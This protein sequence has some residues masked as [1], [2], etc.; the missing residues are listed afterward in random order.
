MISIPYSRIKQF[1][2]TDY[3]VSM[4]HGQALHAFLELDK[5]QDV[6]DRIWC[7]RLYNADESTAI[8]MIEAVTDWNN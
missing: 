5:I 6:D 1:H 7:D 8:K 2:A 4:R 3:P